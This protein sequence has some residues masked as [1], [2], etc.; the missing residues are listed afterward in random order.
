MSRYRPDD[1]A[2]SSQTTGRGW[3]SAAVAPVWPQSRCLPRVAL[4]PVPKI[5][6]ESALADVVDAFGLEV[7][8]PTEQWD[9]A[10]PE[11]LLGGVFK[12]GAPTP[13]EVLSEAGMGHRQP[14]SAVPEFAAARLRGRSLGLGRQAGAES[15]QR[16]DDRFPH[17]Q[18]SK[19]MLCQVVPPGPPRPR[20][21]TMVRGDPI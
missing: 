12:E 16:Q 17:F 18:P 19:P 21:L 1:P 9:E 4:V 14:G 13:Q 20:V 5:V 6:V 15:K 7:A 8:R 3:K 2:R 10:E 11:F